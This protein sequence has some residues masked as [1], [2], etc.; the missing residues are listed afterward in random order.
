MDSMA[1]FYELASS[2]CTQRN[3]KYCINI[4]DSWDTIYTCT[5]ILVRTFMGIMYYPAPNCNPKLFLSS[6]PKPNTT[7]NQG[8]RNV[9]TRKNVLTFQTFPRFDSRRTHFLKQLRCQVC[10]EMEMQCWTDIQT[11]EFCF[12]ISESL[13]IIYCHMSHICVNVHCM[14]A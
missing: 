7:L 9:R 12:V 4:K 14:S 6:S 8:L 1:V 11:D 3:C 5:S 2:K 13:F 10:Q